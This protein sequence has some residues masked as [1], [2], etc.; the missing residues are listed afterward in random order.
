[1]LKITIVRSLLLIVVFFLS[2]VR[3]LTKTTFCLGK[4]KTINFFYFNNYII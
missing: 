4:K 3:K 1:M 2:Q